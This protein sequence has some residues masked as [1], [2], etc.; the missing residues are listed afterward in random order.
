MKIVSDDG[1][2]L[3]MSTGGLLYLASS[4]LLGLA[5]MFMGSIAS[6]FVAIAFCGLLAGMVVYVVN[7]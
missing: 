1:N 6:G 4:L 7:L 2:E 5:I 3:E